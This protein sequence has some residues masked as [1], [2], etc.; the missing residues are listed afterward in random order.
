M[1]K[2]GDF[3]SVEY[4]G[5]DENGEVFDSTKGEIGKELH[6]KDG[7]L[8]VIIGNHRFVPGLDEAIRTMNKGEEREVNIASE[9]AFGSRNKSLIKVMRLSDFKNSDV[10]PYPGLRIPIDTPNGKS[11]GLIK[12]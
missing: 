11:F 8:L 6:G 2:N 7:A 9:K 5:Y 1:L 4:E 10:Y 12:K 3:I